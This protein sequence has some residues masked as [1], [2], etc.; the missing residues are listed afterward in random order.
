MTPQLGG[1]LD[2]QA[3]NIV[4][5]TVNGN[6]TIVP[7][8]T[9]HLELGSTNIITTGKIYFGN[10]FTNEV[11]LPNATTYDGM[12]AI[13]DDIGTAY[14]SHDT[15]WVKLLDQSGDQS[16]SG[17]LTI[18]NLKLNDNTITT[19]TDILFTDGADIVTAGDSKIG[20]YMYKGITS[21]SNS[22][23]TEIFVKGITDNRVTLINNSTKTFDVMITAKRYGMSVGNE[24]TGS[25]NFRGCVVNDDGTTGILGTIM[26]TVF[27]KTDSTYD[28]TVD[29]INEH[30]ALRIRVLGQAGESIKWM[31][32]VNTIEVT[33]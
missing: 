27:G 28:C 33:V 19:D 14:Y 6:I 12:F 16:I 1:D 9:G 2:V 5:S 8:G 23:L 31:A 20:V 15:V 30:D 18:D 25:W 4:T 22:N 17:S 21:V 26:K 29:A 3:R 24:K 11:G 32:V 10:T 7:N 13:A